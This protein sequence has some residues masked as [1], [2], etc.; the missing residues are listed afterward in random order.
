MDGKKRIARVRNAEKWKRMGFGAP[1]QKKERIAKV[2][3]AILPNRV[4]VPLAWPHLGPTPSPEN[5]DGLIKVKQRYGDGLWVPKNPLK[6][7]HSYGAWLEK[8]GWKRL[9]SGA[10]S[11]VFGRDD[12]DKVIKV[13]QTLDNWIDYVQWAAKE[14]FA[15]SLAPRVYSWKRRDNWSVAVVEKMERGGYD[16]NHKDDG[17][18]LMTLTYPARRVISWRSASWKRSNRVR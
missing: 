4:G 5:K 18:L 11:T 15:G 14:G 9:G 10:H 8:K 7:P 17:A 13:T 3:V 1:V 6:G 2:K 12:S 16:T